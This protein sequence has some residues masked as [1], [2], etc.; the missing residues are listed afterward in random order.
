MPSV[1]SFTYVS[2]RVSVG[3]ADLVADVLAQR[4]LEFFGQPRG[5]GAGGQ[6]ARLRV[7]DHPVHAAPQF[8]ADLRQLRRL[9]RARLATDDHNLVVANGRGDVLPPRVDRQ[10]PVVGDPWQT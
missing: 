2:G 5:D 4:R 7:T 8:Q 9:A 1:I 3:E 10:R 6:S